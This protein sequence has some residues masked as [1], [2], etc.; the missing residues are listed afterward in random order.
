[1]PYT[2]VTL[3]R[4][5]PAPAVEHFEDNKMA[6]EVFEQRTRTPR[7]VL[8]VFF[9]NTDGNVTMYWTKDHPRHAAELGAVRKGLIK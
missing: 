5:D 3:M 4:D 9:Y 1:M 7:R 8:A 2:L 6:A